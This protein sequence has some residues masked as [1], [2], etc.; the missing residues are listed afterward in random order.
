MVIKVML[1]SYHR[2]NCNFD[3]ILIL[4]QHGLEISK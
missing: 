4:E 2:N 3:V 1:K